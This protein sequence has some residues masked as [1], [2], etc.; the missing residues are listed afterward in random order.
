[1]TH[2]LNDAGDGRTDEDSTA[3]SERQRPGS[4]TGGEEGMGARD[5]LQGG[6]PPPPLASFHFGG[7][8]RRQQPMDRDRMAEILSAALVISAGEF[9]DDGQVEEKNYRTRR[10]HFDDDKFPPQ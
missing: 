7:D 10:D 1:M 5:V 3:A 6:L 4:E 8:P 2:D 9:G